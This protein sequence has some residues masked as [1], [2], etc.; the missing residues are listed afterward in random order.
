MKPVLLENPTLSKFYGTTSSKSINPRSPMH[1]EISN[2]MVSHDNFDTDRSFT[3]ENNTPWEQSGRD[4]HHSHNHQKGVNTS[5]IVSQQPNTIIKSDLKN[6]L[7]KKISNRNRSQNT[8]TDYQ[9]YKRDIEYKYSQK[10]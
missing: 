2:S 5:S 6:K 7:V 3:D 8:K 4:H 10:L 9:K 1:L